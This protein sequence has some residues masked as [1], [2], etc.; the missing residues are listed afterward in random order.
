MIRLISNF[1]R[2]ALILLLTAFPTKFFA[3]SG[4]YLGTE[5]NINAGFLEAKAK[6]TNFGN[7][8]AAK[9][10]EDVKNSY[11]ALSVKKIESDY[12]KV[13]LLE[14]VYKD[15][16]LTSI[17]GNINGD[18]LYFLVNKALNKSDKDIV[19]L[20][21]R[22]KTKAEKEEQSMSSESLKLWL[23]HHNKYGKKH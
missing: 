22:Y 21:E 8:I 2:N 13:R 15:N 5:R 6:S 11:Y 12:V 3:Q 20:F 4:H 1:S 23:E 19:S 7:H 14:M 10:Y 18:Y 9:I 17:S 16:V